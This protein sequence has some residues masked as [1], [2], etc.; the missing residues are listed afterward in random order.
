[1]AV[2]AVLFL[3]RYLADDKK[4][5]IVNNY[6]MEEIRFMAHPFVELMLDKETFDGYP[7]LSIDGCVVEVA[8]TELLIISI[9]KI[10]SEDLLTEVNF[11][12]MTISPSPQLY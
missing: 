2:K 8:S 12:G 11:G 9:A 1:M 10:V 7:Y 6:E 5:S 4:I 3:N